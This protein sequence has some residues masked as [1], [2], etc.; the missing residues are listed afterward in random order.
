MTAAERRDVS[1]VSAIRSSEAVTSLNDLNLTLAN[2]SGAKMLALI[3]ELLW[4]S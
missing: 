3:E 1:P 4:R 2:E